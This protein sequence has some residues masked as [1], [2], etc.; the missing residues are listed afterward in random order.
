MKRKDH[1]AIDKL[2]FGKEFPEVHKWIDAMFPEYYGFEHWKERHHIEAI[3]KK[4]GKDTILF[5]VAFMHILCDW[6]NHLEEIVIPSNEK[7][8][9]R[10]L[11][12]VGLR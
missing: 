10:I 11:D 2:V 3:E 6:L 4:F 8:V 1:L 5:K 7:E 9:I 12:E